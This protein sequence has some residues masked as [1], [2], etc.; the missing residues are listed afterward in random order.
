M[1]KLCGN[2][3]S[4]P[5]II[6]F[7]NAQSNTY[8]KCDFCNSL[9][10]KVLET[11]FL[12]DFFQELLDNFRPDPNGV[13]LYKVIQNHWN[14]FYSLELSGKILNAIIPNL[15][16]DISNPYERVDFSCE[17]LENI[18]YW[19]VLKEKIKLERRY[20]TDLDFLINELGW[21]GLLSDKTTLGKTIDFYRGRVHETERAEP[22]D[23]KEMYCPDKLK[24]TAGR[25]NS[26]G[27]P[28]LYLCDNKDTV[29]YEIRASYLDEITIGTFS[30]KENITRE[31]TVADFTD[32]ASIFNFE[33]GG[34]T[35][36]I[37]A[38]LLKDKISMDLSKPMRRYDSKL[39]Y[40]P[41]QFICEFIRFYTGGTS[42][43]KFRSS[44]HSKGNNLVIFDQDIMK[45]THVEKLKV[46]NVHIS[47]I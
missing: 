27:I 15:E 10:V 25:A 2:C 11:E 37:K 32:T 13:E 23:A 38:K 9:D 5:E 30:L 14:L 40:I 42:G 34:V 4:D 45:C 1:K 3:F 21:D 26:A 46:K 7:I 16:V 8:G 28:F 43:I 35:S 31:I 33:P 22:I 6:G 19:D 29:L 18:N 44:L 24:S 36:R 17:I 39:D 20:T 41:T 47:A 12:Y